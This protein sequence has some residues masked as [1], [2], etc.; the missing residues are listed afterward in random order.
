MQVIFSD[1]K[2]KTVKIQI[3]DIDDLWHLSHIIDIGDKIISL[4]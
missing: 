3:E 1:F 2:K 4:F